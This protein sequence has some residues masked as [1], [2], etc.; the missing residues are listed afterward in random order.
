MS[1]VSGDGHERERRTVFLSW[2]RRRLLAGLGVDWRE[3]LSRDLSLRKDALPVGALSFV[4][5]SRGLASRSEVPRTLSTPGRMLEAG[6]RS[7][8]RWGGDHEF[9]FPMAAGR[10]GY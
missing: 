9:N 1:N 3:A 7:I 2:H 5:G 8:E 4:L 10:S 6:D